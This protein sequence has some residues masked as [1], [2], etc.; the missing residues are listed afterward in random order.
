M[1]LVCIKTTL[2]FA[3]ICRC[4][5]F[6]AYIQAAQDAL[7]FLSVDGNVLNEKGTKTKHCWTYFHFNVFYENIFTVIDV[8]EFMVIKLYG[9][10]DNQ[11]SLDFMKNPKIWMHFESY[12]I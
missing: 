8:Y 4:D 5:H 12:T 10:K 6:V 9:L 7:L 1:K 3:N 11:Y 2:K